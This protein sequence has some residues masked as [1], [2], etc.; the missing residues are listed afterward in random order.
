VRR[1]A[2]VATVSAALRATVAYAATIP[3]INITPEA[4]P[5][6]KGVAA[7]ILGL[8]MFIAWVVFFGSMI[9]VGVKYMGGD[10]EAP[11]HLRRVLIGGAILA[12]GLSI[13][14]WLFGGG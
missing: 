13:A 11:Q 1:L 3:N 9:Y 4:P 6:V 10:K 2:S 5:E 7:R 12:F 14:Y 8:A